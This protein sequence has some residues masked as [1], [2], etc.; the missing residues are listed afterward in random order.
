MCESQNPVGVSMAVM[1]SFRN[2][3][4]S[5]QRICICARLGLTPVDYSCWDQ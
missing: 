4:N 1:P 5:M 3:S 2:D